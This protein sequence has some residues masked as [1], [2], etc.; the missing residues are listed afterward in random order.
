VE[1]EALKDLME[2]LRKGYKAKSARTVKRR[3]LVMYLCLKVRLIKYF[4]NIACFYSLTFDGW[5]NS[6]VKGCLD[7]AKYGTEFVKQTNRVAMSI[8]TRI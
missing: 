2:L 8:I 1:S 5:S 6:Q 3:L 4:S 7:K